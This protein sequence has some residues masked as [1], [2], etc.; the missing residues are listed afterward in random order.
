VM[1]TIIDI[2]SGA[3]VLAGSTF[4]LVGALGVVRM[5]DVFARMHAAGII[6]SAG[7]GLL[8]AGMMFQAGPN[9]IALKLL[10]LLAIFFFTSPTATHAVARA[11]LHVG[12]EP[13]LAE[14]GNKDGGEAG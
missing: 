9:L 8:I 10:I 4:I 11:A 13:L 1:E 6:D 12:L 5:P 2:I 14:P 3:L 7:A